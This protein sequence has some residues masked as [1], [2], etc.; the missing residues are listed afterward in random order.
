M[1]TYGEQNLSWQGLRDMA[2]SQARY[3]P[4]GQVNEV[5]PNDDGAAVLPDVHRDVPRVGVAVLPEHR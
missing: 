3:W 2:R 1:R 4:D 5:Y